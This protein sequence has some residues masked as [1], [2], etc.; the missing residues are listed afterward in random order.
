M[1]ATP[2]ITRSLAQQVGPGRR[3]AS[4]PR[5]RPGR[6]ASRPR[7]PPLA[8]YARRGP[9]P[10]VRRAG[11]RRTARRRRCCPCP[12]PAARGRRRRPGPSASRTS[13]GSVM[14]E[15][16]AAASPPSAHQRESWPGKSNGGR[17]GRPDLSRPCKPWSASCLADYHSRGD[18]GVVGDR[19]V[20]L[21]DAE[22]GDPPGHRPGAGEVGL[23]GF[24]L[25][26]LDVGPD[27]PG[28][29]APRALAR[30]SLAANRPAIRC[31]EASCSARGE[32]PL[33]SRPSRPAAW[34][35]RD[36]WVTSMPMPTIMAATRP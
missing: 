11:H 29:R 16:S 18:A 14:T 3:R 4:R 26:H 15:A 33:S 10:R 21:P 19:Q 27:Q 13:A 24:V 5:R 6:P 32:H 12:R 17:F 34:V 9:P 20:E 8:R 36:T 7:A 31:I 22:F 2:S 25:A 28:G 1:P 23:A 35:N 30:A